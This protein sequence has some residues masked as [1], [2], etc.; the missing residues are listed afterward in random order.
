M[1]DLVPI[2][3][4]YT[5]SAEYFTHLIVLELRIP[6]KWPSL[7]NFGIFKVIVGVDSTRNA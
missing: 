1:P 7:D 6:K 2:K 3:L 4:I 5:N